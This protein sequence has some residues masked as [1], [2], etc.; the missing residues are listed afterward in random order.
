MA[1]NRRGF[2]HGLFGG[3]TAAGLIVAANPK[4]IEAF[5]TSVPPDSP[6][7]LDQPTPKR[8]FVDAGEHLYNGRGELV[9]I[10]T[11]FT[12]T[13]EPIEVTAYGMS[14]ST[15][16]QGLPNFEI[17]A[18]GVGSIQWD[19]DHRRMPQLRGR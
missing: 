3:V 18:R 8:A 6:V 11:S 1:M 15:Y 10:V 17:I 2:I 16:I 12:V 4:E 13:R 14:E 19:G 7:M 9:A 5:A